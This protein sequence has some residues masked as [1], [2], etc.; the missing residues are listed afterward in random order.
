MIPGPVP[1]QESVT[2][3]YDRVMQTP[4]ATVDD[5]AEKLEQAH[6]VLREALGEGGDGGV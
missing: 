4:A 5:R 1:G 6:Q 3:R 2:A